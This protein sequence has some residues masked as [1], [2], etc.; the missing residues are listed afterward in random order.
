MRP[1]VAALLLLPRGLA[2]RNAARPHARLEVLSADGA[3]AHSWVLQITGTPEHLEEVESVDGVKV[4]KTRYPSASSPGQRGELA[5]HAISDFDALA[6]ASP[7]AARDRVRLR[8]EELL[9]AAAMVGLADPE[10]CQAMLPPVRATAPSVRHFFSLSCTEQHE[11]VLL[12]GYEGSGRGYTWGH[13]SRLFPSSEEFC[14]DA[15]NHPERSRCRKS[16]IFGRL[17][18]AW[19]A[20]RAWD[21]V[22]PTE[23]LRA[24]W[25]WLRHMERSQ[26]AAGVFGEFV[27]LLARSGARADG[28]EDEEAIWS[29]LC[30]DAAGRPCQRMM[31]HLRQLVRLS[32]AAWPTDLALGPALLYAAHLAAEVGEDTAE[33]RL[34]WASL[35]PLRLWSNPQDA[36]D[37]ELYGAEEEEEEEAAP[38]ELFDVDEEEPEEPEIGLVGG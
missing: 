12:T 19:A 15:L 37:T 24:I 25:R 28:R 26:R 17:L 14:E 29:G 3:D 23:E 21:D 1:A 4:L 16:A 36:H 13:L 30:V 38:G 35:P 10:S 8:T 33:A 11:P 20:L 9:R 7:G 27:A 5:R 34:G 22:E 18:V 6:D 2:L 31:G 32:P